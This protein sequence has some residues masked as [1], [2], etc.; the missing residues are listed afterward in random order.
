[1]SRRALIVFDK[2]IGRCRDEHWS[3]SRGALVVV[4]GSLNTCDVEP[5][6]HI[7]TLTTYIVNQQRTPIVYI[8][9]E[10]DAIVIGELQQ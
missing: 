4:G 2:S 9:K 10:S 1:M 3:L 5:T 7:D 8:R 6:L